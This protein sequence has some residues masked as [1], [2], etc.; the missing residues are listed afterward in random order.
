M[1]KRKIL[2]I[3]PY[4]VLPMHYGGRIRIYKLARELSLLNND[5]TILAPYRPGQKAYLK[6]NDNLRIRSVIYPFVAPFLLL[7]KPFPYQFLV[8]FHPGYRYL[9]REHLKGYDIYQFEHV[10]FADLLDHLP[11]KAKV[12]YDAHNVEYDYINSEVTAEGLRDVIM[13]RIY[14][15]E[16]KILGQARAVF[17]CSREDIIR[18]SGLYRADPG[19][20][21]I[22]PNGIDKHAAIKSDG[23]EGISGIGGILAFDRKVI[24]CGS[25]VE[26]N[27]CAVRFILKELAP[28]LK[29]CCAFI[30]AG[31]CA[32]AFRGCRLPNVFFDNDGR[33]ASDY[34]RLSPIAINPVTQGGGTSLKILEYLKCGF[35]V[36]S[37]EF[38]MRGY[39][40]L[41]PLV[42]IET[43]SRFAQALRSFKSSRKVSPEALSKYLWSNIAFK[44]ND[45][46][47]HC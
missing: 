13:K 29:D 7:D 44:A 4:P 47:G 19:N 3:S 2:I 1:I 20:F 26:H 32:K 35:P 46:Y 43:A 23:K 14:H 36:I 37:T 10:A 17:S 22:I 28:E 18:F 39:A 16:N 31:S 15:L 24:F 12:V 5:I 8:S 40:D 27:R 34:A 11:K 45:A 33:D 25:N 6:V 38:G 30:I 9:A 21:L 42:E 41:K